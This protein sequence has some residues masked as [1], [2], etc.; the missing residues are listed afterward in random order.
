MVF[1]LS[2]NNVDFPLHERFLS[3]DEQSFLLRFARRTIECYIHEAERVEPAA[4]E[5]TEGVVEHRATFVTLRKGARLRGC[6]G[7]LAATKPLVLSVR[8]NAIRSA[9]SDPRF[10]PVSPAELAEIA[11][12][13]SALGRGD[14]E[15]KPF[16]RVRSLDEIVIGRDGLMIE[17]PDGPAGLLLPQVATERGW[18]REEF[19]GA[20][21]KKA[22]LPDHAWKQSGI[23]L[24]RFTAQV[25]AESGP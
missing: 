21:C 25:F 24:H 23:V 20:V 2:M 17:L 14:T 9:M 19:L 8:D 15:D 12:E 22:G 3:L 6:I 10:D 5:L 11:I 16:I 4:A 18:G 13:I 7:S 1:R